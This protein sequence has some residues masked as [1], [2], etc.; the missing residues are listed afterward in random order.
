L[1]L[2][3]EKI[4]I[5]CEEI[6]ENI[7]EWDDITFDVEKKAFLINIKYLPQKY[8]IIHELGHIY[9]AKEVKDIRIITNYYPINQYMNMRALLDGIQSH[10]RA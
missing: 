10:H 8:S 1:D 5:R 9:L 4:I 7:F 6:G 2:I 3:D